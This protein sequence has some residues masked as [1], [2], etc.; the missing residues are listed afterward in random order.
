[1]KTSN[2]STEIVHIVMVGTSLLANWGGH[3]GSALPPKKKLLRELKVNPR[4]LSA[5]LNSVIPFIA[6]QECSSVHLVATD[7][8]E[9][10]FCRDVLATWFKSQGIHVSGAEAKDLLPTSLESSTDQATFNRGIR[11]FRELVFRAVR[12]T[13]KRGA[14]VLLNATG[15]LKAQVSVAV[16][17]AAELGIDAYYIHESMTDPIFLPTAPLDPALRRWLRAMSGKKVTRPVGQNIDLDRLE[18]EG[19]VKVSRG[20]DGTATQIRL[21]QYGKYW[22]R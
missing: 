22:A 2:S 3:A 18:S 1:M 8:S 21:T 9:G 5:E 10:R 19:L 15:G 20:A 4:K 13:Q 17:I 6:R 11:L 12:K 14:R 7:T 16:L